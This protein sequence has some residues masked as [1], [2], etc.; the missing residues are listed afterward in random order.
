MRFFDNSE[1]TDPNN[2]KEEAPSNRGFFR[3]TTR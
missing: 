1:I 3:W 2:K